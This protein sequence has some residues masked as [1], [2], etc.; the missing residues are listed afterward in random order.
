MG[1]SEADVVRL[2][3]EFRAEQAPRKETGGQRRKTGS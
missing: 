2:I 1:I 3:Q